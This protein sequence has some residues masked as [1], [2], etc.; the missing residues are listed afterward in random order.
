M[1]S[2]PIFNKVS[3]DHISLRALLIS[4]GELL[5]HHSTWQKQSN[6]AFQ[7]FCL[8]RR[9]VDSK[10][11]GT[12]HCNHNPVL[13]L[14]FLV[15]V[16]NTSKTSIVIKKQWVCPW[17]FRPSSLNWVVFRVAAG[18]SW[19]HVLRDAAVPTAELQGF[20]CAEESLKQRCR[21][22]RVQTS[23]QIRNYNHCI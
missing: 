12:P 9:L 8:L 1:T 7:N 5:L 20:V 19:N 15:V 3:L 17:F 21:R 22:E 2:I 11:V 13:C 10:L 16:K 4:T 6:Q 14:N 18:L 23:P